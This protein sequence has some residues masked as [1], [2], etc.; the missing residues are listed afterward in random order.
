VK[1]IKGDYIQDIPDGIRSRFWAVEG[2]QAFPHS[3]EFPTVEFRDCQTRSGVGVGTP[4]GAEGP[5]CRLVSLS[6]S[7]FLLCYSRPKVE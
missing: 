4:S 1:G 5:V 7:S 6:L 3:L 2:S